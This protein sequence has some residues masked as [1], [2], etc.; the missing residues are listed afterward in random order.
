MNQPKVYRVLFLCTGNSARSILGEALLNHLGKGRFVAYSAGSQ[1]AGRVN[2]VALALLDSLCYDTTHLRSKSWDEFA[3]QRDIT[4]DFVFTV[5]DSAA[6]E[7]CPIWPGHPMMVH[8]GLPDPAAITGTE[9]E[10]RAAFDDTF[11]MLASRIRE[12]V[13]MPLQ[14]MSP[15]AIKRELQLLGQNLTKSWNE[16]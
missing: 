11:A 14:D 8:W 4:F 3:A 7:T 12:F 2:P 5:C 1:P 9:E 16:Q 15:E 13:K 10:I 6:R